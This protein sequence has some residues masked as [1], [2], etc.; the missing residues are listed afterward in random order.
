[1]I[2]NLQTID[3]KLTNN[4]YK[5]Y[6]L[7]IQNLQTFDTKPTN[8]QSFLLQTADFKITNY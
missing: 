4:W 2:Q 7:M 6:E 5:T 1:M 3:T 8:Y